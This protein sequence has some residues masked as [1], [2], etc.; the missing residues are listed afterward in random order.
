MKRRTVYLVHPLVHGI[1]KFFPHNPPAKGDIILVDG[2]EGIHRCRVVRNPR[3]S[4]KDLTWT[5]HGPIAVVSEPEPRP[6]RDWT[7][8]ATWLIWEDVLAIEGVLPS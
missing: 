3:L 7:M 1:T 5:L 4:W 8:L 2:V 6:E